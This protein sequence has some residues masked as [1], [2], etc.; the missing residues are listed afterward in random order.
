MD[1]NHLTL[2]MYAPIGTASRLDLGPLSCY[3]KDSLFK[4][5]LNTWAHPGLLPP[6]IACPLIGH[7]R[8]NIR[9][10]LKLALFE[11]TDGFC[12]TAIQNFS[13]I[14]GHIAEKSCIAVAKKHSFSK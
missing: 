7:N 12:A 14:W 13:A 11:K 10:L 1:I 3:R 6:K 2:S 5:F 9:P 8:F 4:R